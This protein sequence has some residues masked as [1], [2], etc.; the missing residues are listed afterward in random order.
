MRKA[1]SK[2]G[3]STIATLLTPALRKRASP[4]FLRA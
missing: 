4:S 1:S 3:I 2:C